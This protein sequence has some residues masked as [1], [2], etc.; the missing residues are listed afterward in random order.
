VPK[1]EILDRSDC[2]GF[3]TIKSP[4]VGDFGVKIK[5]R[6]YGAKTMKIKVIKYFTFGCL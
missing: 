4:L 1:C 2:N 5:F 3:Y 6:F